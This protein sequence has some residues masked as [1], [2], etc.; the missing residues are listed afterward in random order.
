MIKRYYCGN[1]GEAD[2]YRFESLHKMRQP[3]VDR[4]KNLKKTRQQTWSE[5]ARHDR[6]CGRQ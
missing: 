1:C 2:P 5:R 4:K 6:M 3:I